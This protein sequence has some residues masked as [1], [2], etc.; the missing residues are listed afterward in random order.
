MFRRAYLLLELRRL[1][2]V[3]IFGELEPLVL[4]RLH[5]GQLLLHLLHT[6][7]HNNINDSAVT[8]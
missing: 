6:P 5:H 3:V 4:G 2:G 8:Q 1:F 7:H